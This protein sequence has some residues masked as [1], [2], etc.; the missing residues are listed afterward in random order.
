M[1]AI[2]GLSKNVLP[3]K[4]PELSVKVL[5]RELYAVLHEPGG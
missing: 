3:V 2:G 4:Q 1:V 5:C